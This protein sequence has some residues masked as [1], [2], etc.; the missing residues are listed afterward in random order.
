M[1]PEEAFK[2]VLKEAWEKRQRI[3]EIESKRELT[4]EDMG[5]DGLHVVVTKN[6]HLWRE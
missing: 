4:A 6:N 1:T 2:V 5:N 3:K